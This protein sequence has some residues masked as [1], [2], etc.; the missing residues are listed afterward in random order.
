MQAAAGGDLLVGQ[1][2]RGIDKVLLQPICRGPLKEAV[3]GAKGQFDH[4]G[5]GF[6]AEGKIKIGDQLCGGA[7]KRHIGA[8]GFALYKALAQAQL[9]QQPPGVF[10]CDGGEGGQ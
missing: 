5:A 4:L 7:V 1:P 6:G 10:L 9:H 3:A 2:Q 8:F